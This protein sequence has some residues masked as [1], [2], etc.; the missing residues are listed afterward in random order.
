MNRHS[1]SRRVL[2][3]V[4][5]GVLFLC[6][7]LSQIA[8][9]WQEQ[10]LSSTQTPTAGFTPAFFERNDDL[11][12]LFEALMNTEDCTLPCWWGLQPGTSRAS[13]IRALLEETGFDRNLDGPFVL[14]TTDALIGQG[15]GFHF[16]DITTVT[17]VNLYVEE[18]R[19][20]WTLHLK[21]HNTTSR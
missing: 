8:G 16:V 12:P 3:F 11:I 9:E 18:R 4:G 20:S 17:T 10:E 14:D 5:L 15:V 6:A 7:W 2:S 1:G 21:Q 13:D 19:L